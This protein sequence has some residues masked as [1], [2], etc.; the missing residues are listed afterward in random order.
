MATKFRQYSEV[1]AVLDSIQKGAG[2]AC[3]LVEMAT[4]LR[5]VLGSGPPFRTL[6]RRASDRNS[7]GAPQGLFGLIEIRVTRSHESRRGCRE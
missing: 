2:G 4:K 5:L 3:G 6:L 1:A 7:S